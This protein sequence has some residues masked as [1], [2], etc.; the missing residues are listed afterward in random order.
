[1]ILTRI[2]KRK[3][4][5]KKMKIPMGSQRNLSP[6]AKRSRRMRLW[7]KEVTETIPW[8]VGHG[9][10][11]PPDRGLDCTS[12]RWRVVLIAA[13][14]WAVGHFRL[15]WIV[16]LEVHKEID[17]TPQASKLFQYCNRWFSDNPD[18][19]PESSNWEYKFECFRSHP[20]RSG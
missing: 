9:A 8:G 12:V 14:T 18:T 20:H 17:R 10:G 7:S 2:S 1:M 6:G 13:T 3:P 15:P 4:W 16:R 11:R 5:R 19:R